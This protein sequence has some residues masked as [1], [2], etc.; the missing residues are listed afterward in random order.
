MTVAAKERTCPL[1]GNEA[2]SP[3]HIIPRSEG[4]SDNL[5]NI[6]YLCKKC[7]DDIEENWNLFVSFLKGYANPR[8]I[9]SRSREKKGRLSSFS[10]TK[11]R[12]SR[13]AIE[14]VIASLGTRG[15]TPNQM[16]IHLGVRGNRVRGILRAVYSRPKEKRRKRWGTLTLGNWL[17]VRE[18]AK[19]KLLN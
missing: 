8:R 6:V 10:F 2:N 9:L 1:C 11:K 19:S 12:R 14:R 15:G 18:L 5:G 7:H 16:A 3:H 13:P 17:E 4:G